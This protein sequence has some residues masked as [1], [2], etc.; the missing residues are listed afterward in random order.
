MCTVLTILPN[1]LVKVVLPFA[2]GFVHGPVSAGKKYIS[3]S[4][5]T[6]ISNHHTRIIFC[7]VNLVSANA[8]IE[9]TSPTTY[10]V[11]S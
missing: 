9:Q 7:D 5:Y 4:N 1:V 10:C 3:N 6:Q 8:N 2:T 11:I